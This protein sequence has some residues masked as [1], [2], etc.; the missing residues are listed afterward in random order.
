[1]SVQV[2]S[3]PKLQAYLSTLQTVDVWVDG[4][5]WTGQVLAEAAIIQ[6]GKICNMLSKHICSSAYLLRYVL[7]QHKIVEPL[8]FGL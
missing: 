6:Q 8:L 3:S 4:A 5:P 2:G 1:M 7:N